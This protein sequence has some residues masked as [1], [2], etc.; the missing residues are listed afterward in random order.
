MS[1]NK[2]T[3][4][5][6]P[7]CHIGIWK[8]AIPEE[9]ENADF[10]RFVRVIISDIQVQVPKKYEILRKEIVQGVNVLKDGFMMARR[11]SLRPFWKPLNSDRH[12][13]IVLFALRASARTKG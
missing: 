3:A 9:I 5:V 2:T 11:Q 10:D 8:E 12:S 4:C 6:S 7:H 1:Q 13:V